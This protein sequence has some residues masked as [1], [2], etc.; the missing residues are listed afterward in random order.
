MR[1][2]HTGGAASLGITVSDIKVKT[3]GKIKFK[4]IRTVTNKDGQNI[5]ISRAG[6]IIVSDTMGRVREQH[7]IPMGAVVPLASGKGV[8]IGDVIATWDPHAQPLITDVAGKVVLE[9]VID[10][11]TSKHTYDDLTGQQTIEITSISQRTTSKNL[12]PVVKVVDEKGNELK[13]ISLAVGAVLNVTDDSVLEVGDVVAKIPLEGSKNKDITGGLPR[14]AELFEAR[15]PKDAAI[16]S[17]CDG[18][19]RLG[20]RDTKEKQR[21]E[22]LDKSGHIAEEMLLPKSRH[23][24]VFDGEQ[25]S[26]GDVLADGPTDPHDLLKY[27]GLE[28]FADYI[29]I[30]AQS[31]YRMQGVVINDKHIETIVRQM[32]RKQQFLMKVIVS[33]SK[34]KVLN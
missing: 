8:E 4:N 22:I 10:G 30:E 2:F 13:S 26:K 27:K 23:L 18:M 21:I 14:V 19:V 12:K 32:L 25:V 33:L 7:K 3:A 1:T 15:R 24:V 16:L 28:A 31:V 17:P 9:D 20:N 6:E 34:M 29:L 5:V 11:I